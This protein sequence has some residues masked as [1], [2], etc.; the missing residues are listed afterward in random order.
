MI[1]HRVAR[2]H[3]NFSDRTLYGLFVDEVINTRANSFV[4]DDPLSLEVFGLDSAEPR[5]RGLLLK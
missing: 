2:A 4:S 5:W 1:W 3:L